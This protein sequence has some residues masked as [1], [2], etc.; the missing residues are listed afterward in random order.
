MIKKESELSVRKQC[1]LLRMNRSTVYHEPA[2]PTEEARQQREELMARLD[3]WHTKFCGLGTRKLVVLL[4][5]EGYMVGRKRVRRLMR[6]MGLYT[7]YPKENL[8]KR[9]F[10]EAIVPYL[11][12]N[13]QIQFSNEVWSVDITYIKLYQ[14]H[15]YLTAIIDW[16]SRKIMGW[17][18]SDTLST[19][20]VLAAI[21]KA[22]EK[23]GTPAIIN[24]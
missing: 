12:R 17:E 16:H 9:N 19:A 11:L 18:L 15:M 20:P 10:K 13:R 14:R 22:V 3:W 24:P 4:R 21:R 7:V 2:V 6:E 5:Q 8:S 1:D 23:Y